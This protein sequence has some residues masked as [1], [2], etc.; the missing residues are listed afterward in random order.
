MSTLQMVLVLTVVVLLLAWLWLRTRNSK[1]Q[2]QA[3]TDRLDTVLG[4][5]PKATRVLGTRER[6]AY[7]ILSRGLP[8]FMILA[9]VPLS[10]FVS[11]PKRNSY[12]DWLRRVGYQCV[13]LVVCDSVA[14]VVAVVDLQSNQTNERARKRLQRMKRTL[15]AA[16]IP[17]HLWS[18]D[19]LPSPEAARESIL[20][21]TALA[22]PKRGETT[23]STAA[24]IAEA[25]RPILGANPFDELDRDSSQDETIE[26]L[27]PPPSTWFDE[28][29]S[30]PVPLNKR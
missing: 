22:S 12:A 29:D 20:P 25:A 15:E 4:W 30:N 21:R 1:G 17:L 18:E 10:R 11:V 13:D 28:F 23:S 9:Q 19:A 6:L 16:E 8:E 24:A 26:L 14:Q 3:V 5:P 7:T 27:E 2:G